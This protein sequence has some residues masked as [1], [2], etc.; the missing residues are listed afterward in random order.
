MVNKSYTS[1]ETKKIKPEFDMLLNSINRVSEIECDIAQR[2]EALDKYYKK[3]N[4]ILVLTLVFVIS[5][6]TPSSDTCNYSGRE[7]LSLGF[8]SVHFVCVEP[9]YACASCTTVRSR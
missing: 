4:Q 1:V 7:A 8:G 6:V 5:F 3:W 9:V 2:R